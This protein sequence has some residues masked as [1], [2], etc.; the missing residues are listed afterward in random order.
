[1]VSEDLIL[2]MLC[3]HG[4]SIDIGISEDLM[5]RMHSVLRA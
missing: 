2:K 5:M 3:V 1:M 4:Y